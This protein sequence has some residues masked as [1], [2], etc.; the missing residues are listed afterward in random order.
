M[1]DHVSFRERGKF[2]D[3]V[4]TFQ[5]KKEKKMEASIDVTALDQSNAYPK[6]QF[7]LP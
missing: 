5:K 3:V 7:F 6:S 2:H 4:R 1:W